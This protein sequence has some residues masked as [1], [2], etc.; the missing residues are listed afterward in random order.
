[1]GKRHRACWTSQNYQSLGMRCVTGGES[2]VAR[3]Q[4]MRGGPTAP[5]FSATSGPIGWLMIR[6]PPDP[7]PSVEP[8]ATMLRIRNETGSK[9]FDRI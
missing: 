4:R 5:V 8:Y 6:A 7:C 9:I 1:M 2:R 3:F